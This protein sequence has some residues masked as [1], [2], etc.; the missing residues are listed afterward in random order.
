MHGDFG[1]EARFARDAADFDRAIGDFG[2]FQLEQF[3]DEFGMR[4][5]E[6]HLMAARWRFQAQQQ[7][8]NAVADLVIFAL[9]AFLGGHDAF[10][11]FQVHDDVAAFKAL[12]GAGDNAADV[13]FVGG[14]HFVFF[15]HAQFL[16]DGLLGCLRRDAAKVARGD[17]DF[18]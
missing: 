4:P 3:A 14:V 6:H 15:G 5:R 17:F 10:A 2:D 1:A 11:V 8:A 13:V 18:D 16:D 12:H 7:K 9:D